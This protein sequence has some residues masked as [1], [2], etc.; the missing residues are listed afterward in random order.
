MEEKMKAEEQGKEFKLLDS[1]I[2]AQHAH[3]MENQRDDF[4]IGVNTMD[5]NS[6]EI[7][8]NRPR[9]S[10]A[11]PFNGCERTRRTCTSCAPAVQQLTAYM[12]A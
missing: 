7:T 11:F 12:N 2:V 6:T 8:N 3:D 10:A 5:L 9:K 1:L 4:N